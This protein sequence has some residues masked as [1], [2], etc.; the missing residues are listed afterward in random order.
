[1]KNADPICDI[2]RA[3]TSTGF[4]VFLTTIALSQLLEDRT[5]PAFGR[6]GENKLG[7]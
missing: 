5:E 4:E 1:V 6:L 3:E 7:L 2:I